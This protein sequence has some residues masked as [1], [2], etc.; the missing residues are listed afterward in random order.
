MSDYIIV[1]KNALEHYLYRQGEGIIKKRQHAGRWSAPKCIYKDG[2]DGFCVFADNNGTVHI[3]SSNKNGEL[4][5]LFEKNNTMQTHILLNGN[6]KVYPKQIRTALQPG[7]TSIIYSATYGDETLLIYCI[8][9]VNSK[10]LHIDTLSREHSDFTV[11]GTK[12]YYTNS[13]NILGYMDFSD[14][15]PD[16]FVP[17]CE[18]A[19]MPTAIL[20]DKNEH[21]IYKKENSIICNN[22]V[23][24]E[25][26]HAI[27]P[28]L[29]ISAG[30]LLL[31]WKSQN[32]IKYSASQNGG[33]TWS[34][35]MRFVNSGNNSS[36]FTVQSGNA[37]TDYYGTASAG[38]LH[39]IGAGNLM[40]QA[41]TAQSTAATEPLPQNNYAL[42]KDEVNELKAELNELKKH[43]AN[44]TAIIGSFSESNK[45]NE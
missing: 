38:E 10:P 42:L 30:K 22:T 4:V 28:L 15:K 34:P 13:K 36:I 43:I 12:I 14:G 16:T 3:L 19:Y 41:F 18:N 32:F 6:D 1:Q 39:I 8:L 24:F 35:P 29:C 7:R 20:F 2:T 37:F 9:G 11:A 31:L 23:L 5:Y 44:L 40:P 33:V 27:N 26:K 45:T 17:V 21:I 25:D